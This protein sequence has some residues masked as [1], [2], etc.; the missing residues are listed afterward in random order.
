MA[1]TTLSPHELADSPTL[2]ARFM[3]RGG[4]RPQTF[5]ELLDTYRLRR[6]HVAAA[7][8]RDHDLRVE[9][10]MRDMA[11]GRW[12][13]EGV[14]IRLGEFDGMTL[15]VDGIHRGI[16]YL[17]CLAEGVARERLPPLHVDR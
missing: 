9:R 13:G 11:R 1:L 17:G 14:V 7:G 6:R 8:D 10:F 16:A 2:Y 3:G 5:A 15:A 4:E 12:R